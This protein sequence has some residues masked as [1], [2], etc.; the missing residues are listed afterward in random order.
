MA[1]TLGWLKRH[2]VRATTTVVIAVAALSLWAG[3]AAA[4]DIFWWLR[5]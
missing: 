3:P 1:T 2:A 5:R 4:F